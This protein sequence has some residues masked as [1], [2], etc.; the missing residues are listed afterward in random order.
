MY[1]KC[2][3]CD[4][5]VFALRLLSSEQPD[6]LPVFN[7]LAAESYWALWKE[8]DVADSVEKI[9]PGY[10]SQKLKATFK[11]TR[12][13]FNCGKGLAEPRTAQVVKPVLSISC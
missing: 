4:W 7:K 6:G 2:F 5:E 11:E 10:S 9:V 13:C 3:I 1:K 8:G 12:F